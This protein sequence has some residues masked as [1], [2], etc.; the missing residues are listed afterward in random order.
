MEGPLEHLGVVPR[1]TNDYAGVGFVWSRPS[2]TSKTV[3]HHNEYVAETFYTM[4]LSPLI[5][6][7]PDLQLVWNPAFN[8]DPGPFTIVQAQIILSW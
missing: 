5:R 2:T 4:Q 8:P 1:L 6:L 7:Q 3:Y